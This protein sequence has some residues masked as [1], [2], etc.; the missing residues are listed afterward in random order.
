[1]KQPLK[2][3]IIGGGNMG[4]AML[5]GFLKQGIAP[6]YLMVADHKNEH[7]QQVTKL[8]EVFATTDNAKLAESVDVLILAIKPQ[9]MP[10]VVR[11]MASCITHQLIVSVAAGVGTDQIK[12]WLGNENTAIIRAM[13]NTPAVIGEGATA[14]FANASVTQSQK[15]AVQELMQSLGSVLWVNKESQ[16]HVVTALSG[17]GPAYFFYMLENLITA[18]EA[19]GLSTSQA[20]QLTLQTALG[21]IQMALKSDVDLQT[22]RRKV[23]SKGGTTERGIQILQEGHF[24]ELILQ[25]VQQAAERSREISDTQQ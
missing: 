25:A 21:S 3:G 7:C 19:L 18:G 24:A 10:I 9:Q 1:M 13:P 17:S 4:Q 6:Q 12:A 15:D 20:E 14:L 23:T 5:E 16:M 11:E 8:F 22:L 2:I